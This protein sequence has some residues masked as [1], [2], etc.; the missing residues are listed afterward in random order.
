[1]T[2]NER[3][4]LDLTVYET[5]ITDFQD[6]VYSGK[7]ES[8]HLSASVDVTVVSGLIVSVE[9]TDYTGIDIQRAAKVTDCV[10]IYQMLNV[11][12][13]NIGTEPT[14]IIVLKS[15]E[16]ALSGRHQ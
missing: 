11:P 9:I 10:V 12:D 7:Y 2:V 13:D 8:S 4:V 1:M 14:D 16:Y 6:G 5:D 3:L 15:V